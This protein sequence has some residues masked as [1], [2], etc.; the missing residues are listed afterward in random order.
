[1]TRGVCE[2]QKESFND[3]KQKLKLAFNSINEI[4]KEERN[5]K[6]HKDKIDIFTVAFAHYTTQAATYKRYIYDSRKLAKLEKSDRGLENVRRRIDSWFHF[7]KEYPEGLQWDELFPDD[8]F[9]TPA[10]STWVVN[11]YVLKMQFQPWKIS[12]TCS[13]LF[14]VGMVQH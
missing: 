10:N 5:P 13:F 2:K 11:Q 8:V 14:L 12:S 7:N 1:M 4:N 3:A 6:D 9:S